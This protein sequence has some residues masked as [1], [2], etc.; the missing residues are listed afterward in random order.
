MTN[1]PRARISKN[2]AFTLI[3]LLVVIAIIALLAAILFPVFGRARENARR[4]SCQSNL[5]QAGLGILQYAQDYDEINVPAQIQMQFTPAPASPLEVPWHYL[6]QPYV[7]S[8]QVLKC[9]SYSKTSGGN[10]VY[11]TGGA[12]EPTA[13]SR[14]YYANGGDE[15]TGSFGGKR[16]F[17]KFPEVVALASVQS[18]AT[19]IA[20]CELRGA[21][22]SPF[23]DALAYFTNATSDEAFINHL[24]TT[25]FLFMDGHVKALKP[26]ATATSTI[27]M[28]TNT[29]KTDTASP[30]DGA[31]SAL[32][33]AMG[34]AE[35]LLK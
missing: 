23:A 14:S 28:W 12:N 15:G 16:P 20:V 6:I 18:P 34:T 5:K 33:T 10:N 11:H 22:S 7:R 1:I 2:S 17:K 13:I 26:T 24:S 31:P 8:V 25:N 4:S 21:A 32:I 9:P 3:E 27:N 30:T 35:G 29:N 19:T